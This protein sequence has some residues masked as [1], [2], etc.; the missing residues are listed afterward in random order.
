MIKT[1]KIELSYNE[2][3]L[4][5]GKVSV[6]AQKIINRAKNENIHCTASK[7]DIP[8]FGEIINNAVEKGI[9]TWT[10]KSIR[11]CPFC[12]KQHDYQE[13]KGTG[14]YHQK[15]DKNFDKPKYY[16][17][18]K[19]NE[20]N[21]IFKGH[22]DICW[23]CANKFNLIN[24][25][26][27]YIIDNDL[28]VEIQKNDYKTTKYVLDE[29][30]KCGKCHKTI[31]SIYMG[32][33]RN[34]WGN[35][36][37]TT[38]NHCGYSDFGSLAEKHQSLGE[39]IIYNPAFESDSLVKKITEMVKE[40]NLK[41]FKDDPLEFYESNAQRFTYVLS[42][43]S[44]KNGHGNVIHIN[45]VNKNYVFDPLYDDD[46]SSDEFFAKIKTMLDEAGFKKRS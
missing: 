24:S 6:E 37:K 43:K 4:L 2:I 42:F 30:K 23:D 15:G 41:K 34:I 19:F 27:D 21:I 10:T 18:L 11:S 32:G 28:K 14:R 16:H 12:D 46:F 13:Y 38:C 5:D 36:V 1:Y 3:L 33:V 20:G 45:T 31:Y 44:F 8:L 26:I 39:E 9:L 25:L 35:V 7:I 22:G 40:I 17:G 29:A